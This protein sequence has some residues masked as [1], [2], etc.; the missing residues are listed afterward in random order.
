MLTP[1]LA[2][3]GMANAYY[4]FTDRDVACRRRLEKRSRIMKKDLSA[5]WGNV[6]LGAWLFVSAFLWPHSTAQFNNSWLVGIAAATVAVIAM[7]VDGARYLN[8]ALAAW[9][10]IAGFTLPVSSM[11]T[12]WNNLIVS[13]MMF[14]TALVPNMHARRRPGDQP[15][16]AGAPPLT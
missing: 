11:G 1:L 5:R 13:V 16:M 12:F 15:P 10:F 3:A 6:A 14:F 4:A 8:V 7:R 9:L 2:A